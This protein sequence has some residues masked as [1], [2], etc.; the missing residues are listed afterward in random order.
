MSDFEV[1]QQS[2]AGQSSEILSLNGLAF[3][4]PQVL[5]TTTQRN[6]IKQYSQ[7]QTHNAGD[8]VVFDINTGS[9]Y[10]SPH[11]CALKLEVQ[12]S[13]GGGGD[14]SKLPEIGAYALINEIRIFSKS[15]V[16][17]DRIQDVN[18]YIHTVSP[19]VENKDT[20]DNY[21]ENSGKDKDVANNAT[22]TFILPMSRL[23]GLFNPT[24]KDMLMPSGLISGARIELVLETFNRAFNSTGGTNTG[25]TI[26]NPQIL[27]V[28]HTLNDTT[29][30]VLNE[31]SVDNGAEYTYPRVFS[32]TLTT[33]DTSL[34]IQVKKAV[35]QLKRVMTCGILA[36][37]ESK[38]GVDSFI[39]PKTGYTTW[40]QYQYR[41]GSMFQ[42][43]QNSTSDAEHLWVTQSSFNKHMDRH[44]YGG[45][46]NLTDY[47]AKYYCVGAG[48]ETNM[49][50]NNSGV[51]VN[52][53]AILELQ[54]TVAPTG[55]CKYYTFAEYVAVAKV[56]LMAV[57]VKI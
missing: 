19:F 54:A 39:T 55:A 57:S 34:N 51:P 9:R 23:S 52:N 13:G 15:G 50:L 53:S 35:A 46:V 10:I 1:K 6:I 30:R 48:F 5:S 38:T 32:S 20:I 17:L 40:S 37:E 27:M 56:R 36:T 31:Q 42:P 4:M 47:L 43:N 7:R 28:A 41:V 18:Q 33:T 12:T 8:T 22:S 16:E 29:Q 45:A 26:T 2:V 49:L 24:V 21:F 11:D 14:D 44:T 25:Y 3:S